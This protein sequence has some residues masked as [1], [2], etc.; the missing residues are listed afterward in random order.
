MKKLFFRLISIV[1]TLSI[2]LLIALH[3]LSRTP[4]SRVPGLTPLHLIPSRGFS[5]AVIFTQ[6][7]ILKAFLGNDTISESF[8]RLSSTFLHKSYYSVRYSMVLKNALGK[9]VLFASYKNGAFVLVTRPRFRLKLLRYFVNSEKKDYDGITVYKM[10]SIYFYFVE[11]YLVITPDLDI[12]KL[13]CDIVSGERKGSVFDN[14]GYPDNYDFSMIVNIRKPLLS[15][16]PLVFG[17]KKDKMVIRVKPLSSV[18]F[19]AIKGDLPDSLPV[20]PVFLGIKIPYLELYDAYVSHYPDDAL[21]LSACFWDMG[22]SGFLWLNENGDFL[23]SLDARVPEERMV[24]DIFTCLKLK[25][26]ADRVIIDT[27][28]H[29]YVFKK[30]DFS[31]YFLKYIVDV[32]KN[33]FILTNSRVLLNAYE[34]AQYEKKDGFINFVKIPEY[35]LPASSY[36]DSIIDWYVK[37]DSLK[38][39]RWML[40]FKE[41]RTEFYIE[42]RR[43]LRGK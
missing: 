9:Y 17:L 8:Y 7:K 37:A 5:Y 11:D 36:M 32:E 19:D 41:Y 42:G 24:S 29:T 14:A 21:D 4:Q 10:G 2:G 34:S 23:F 3:I 27:L 40:D 18:I 33:R 43:Y 35:L 20:A 12:L 39:K 6:E 22:G 30:G 15:F 28:S 38:N 13:S 31:A 16:N 25:K 26:K 1:F